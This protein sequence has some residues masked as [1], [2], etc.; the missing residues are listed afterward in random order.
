MGDL[1]QPAQSGAGPELKHIV[2]NSTPAEHRPTP[3]RS[4]H[5]SGRYG[6][7]GAAMPELENAARLRCDARIT[8]LGVGASEFNFAHRT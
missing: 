3:A 6:E 8:V 1:R 4:C 7:S 5:R 2:P